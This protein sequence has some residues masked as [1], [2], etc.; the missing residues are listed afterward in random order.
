[1]LSMHRTLLA[2]SIAALLLNAPAMAAPDATAKDRAEMMRSKIY[3]FDQPEDLRD[4]TTTP[5]SR[6]ALSDKRAIM[7]EQALVWDWQRGG[8]LLLRHAMNIPTDAQVSKIWGRAATPVLSF[9]I[10][11]EHPIDDVLTVDLGN[12][13]NG[14]NEADAGTQVKLNFRGWRAVGVSLNNDLANREM[15]GAGVRSDED[16][17]EPSVGRTLGDR[18]DT[19]RFRA[20]SGEKSGRLFIDR[21]MISVDDARYQWSDYH[22]KTRYTEPE[23]QF[24]RATPTLAMTPASQAGVE[25]IRQRLIDEFVNGPQ[26]STLKAEADLGKLRA[27]FDA[28][29]I[30]QAADGTLSGRHLITDKQKILYQPEHLSAQDKAKFDRYVILGD[31][32]TLM[33]NISHAYRQNSDPAVQRQLAD[34]YLLMT[35]HLL[36]QGF[37][38]GSGLVTT[39]HWGYSARWWYISA[40]LM[41]PVLD[42]ARLTQPVYDALLWYSREFKASFDMKVG[43]ES[44]NLDY[45]NTLSR[46]HLALLLLEPDPQQRIDLLNSFSHYI[47]DALAQTPPGSNDGLRPDGTAWR[48]EGNYPGYSFPAFKNAAQLAYLL[49][50]TPFALQQDGLDK[51][52]Q[53]MVAAWIYSNPQTGISLAGR[54]PFNSPSLESLTNAYYWLAISYDKRPDATLAAIYLRLANK[55]AADAKTLFGESLQPAALPQGFYAFNGGAFGI[56]RWH[57]KMVTLKAFNSNVWSSEIYLKDNRYGRYQSHGVVQIASLGPQEEQGYRQAGWDW[58]RMPGATTLHLPLEALNSPNRHTLMQRGTH[59]FSGTSS[60]DGRY[61]MLAFDLRPMRDQPSFD[62]ALSALKSVLAVDDRL[63]MV[64]S[65][66]NSS[67]DKH[68]LETTLFQLANAAGRDSAIWVNGQRIDA[69]TWQGSLQDGDWLI[70]ADGNGYLLVQGP[71]AEVRRQLQHSADNKSMAPTEGEFSVAWLN[72]GKAVKNG[73]YQYLVV[74]DA[75][76]QRMHGLAQQLKQG[77]APFTVIH[78]QDG[79]HVIRDNASQVTGYVFYRTQTLKDGPVIG[80]NRPAIVMTRPQDDGL[81]LSA[82]TPDLNMTRQKAAKPVTIEVTLRGRWQ[83]AAPADGIACT[84]RGDETRLRFSIDFGIPQQIALKKMP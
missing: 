60:L 62:Q 75:T 17:A 29:Q 71:T 58:N 7:G 76:P 54:H 30:R 21:V 79:V 23:I 57:D 61:G 59:P 56:H 45:F 37:A 50:G 26:D 6:V 63:I 40:L 73:A 84:A 51:L 19:I 4:I 49:R 3:S 48:H 33:F 65:D 44:S 41:N 39:H 47:S 68:A 77:N 18:I 11:N 74:L 52:K 27:A 1:M 20:P 38:R 70:D 25:L 53:A 42:Q 81:V 64:G 22:V 35:R 24:H 69:A 55:T 31:Y 36:D 15:S 9:W 32:T 28:L 83:P 80:V 2:A 46:Q 13:L 5:G 8:S 72:H 82:V 16:A 78:S 14:T 66:L 43:P 67:D 10:Y 34:M 12:G